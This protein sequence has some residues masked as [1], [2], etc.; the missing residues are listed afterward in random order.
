MKKLANEN[1][2]R[3]VDPG[4]N[5][6]YA[7]GVNRGLLALGQPLPDVLLLN[8]D[9]EISGDD[10]IELQ[11]CL[12]RADNERVACVAPELLDHSGQ[13]VPVRWPYP[14]PKQAWMDAMGLGRFTGSSGFLIG[15]VL[16]LRSEALLEV[17]VFDEGF[18][19]YAEE[20]DWQR[21][22]LTFGWGN[23]LCSEV[24][25]RHI[26]GAT[27]HDSM[28]REAHFHASAER[29]VRKWCGRRGWA[30]FRLGVMAGALARIVIGPRRAGHWDRFLRYLRGP[31]RVHSSASH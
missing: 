28:L 15:P 20:T 5:I 1:G 10:V 31:M 22:A 29:Y 14:S 27:S 23:H 21:R 6:G 12:R 4:E 17:G 30:V 9:A 18:F 7:A 26:G 13:P 19:L 24:S 8:P 2:C 25:A 16:L 11:L 3:Y